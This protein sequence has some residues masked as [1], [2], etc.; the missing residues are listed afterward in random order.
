MKTLQEATP[1]CL[2]IFSF[3]W[4][5]GS[6]HRCASHS[7]LHNSH[8][9]SPIES[10]IPRLEQWKTRNGIVTEREWALEE[11]ESLAGGQSLDAYCR[12]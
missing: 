3:L 2:N 11:E 8:S 9:A 7:A 10:E 4:L 5:N 1:Q 12:S 6:N